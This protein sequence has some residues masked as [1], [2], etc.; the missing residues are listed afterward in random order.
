MS[1]VSIITPVYNSADYIQET[2]ESV[3]NQTF[4]NWEWILID[5]C[6]TDKSLSIIQ[7]M[8]SKDSRIKIIVNDKNIK[9]ALSR[10]RGIEIATGKYIAFIDSDDLWHP[11][12]LEKQVYF[13]E[14]NNH[15][16]SYH[17]FS[18]F[19]DTE[20]KIRKILTVPEKISF[21]DLVKTS[22]IGSLAAMYN[23]KVIGKIMMPDGYKAK[24]DYLCWLEILKRC[25]YAFGMTDILG[26]YRIHP[27][28]YSYNKKEAAFNQWRVY[29]E[30]L[31]LN[32]FSSSLNF[33]SYAL[34]GFIKHRF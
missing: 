5:D 21:S 3:L 17:S 23:C 7:K 18:M 2:A 6:S 29:R 4:K 19:Y 13:M 25:D 24:E 12:K 31:K 30:Y 32:I 11:Q 8:A 16:F 34:N 27:H 10:N 15:Y 1:K 26:Y 22:S 33:F 9:T 14:S 20:R 28:S